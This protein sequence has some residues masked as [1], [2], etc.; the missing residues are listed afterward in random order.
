MP[1]NTVFHKATPARK[2]RAVEIIQPLMVQGLSARRIA[3]VTG[4]NRETVRR[5]V[6]LI[7]SKWSEITESDRD[8]WRGRFIDTYNWMLSE[9]AEQWA[10]SKESRET[11]VLNPD[12]SMM[13]RQEPPDPRW[14]SGMLAVAKEAS[15]Y[16]GLREG[17]DQVSRI[18][19]PDATRTALAPMSSDSYLAMIAAQGGSLPGVNSVPLVVDR[20]VE[21][22]DVVDQGEVKEG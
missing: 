5:D 21:V 16:L 7:R 12:G 13:V 18:E 4:L 20:D 10:K 6:G 15:T 2:E 19:V 9:L 1:A 8:K 3:E 14:M 11:R 22:V 17:A